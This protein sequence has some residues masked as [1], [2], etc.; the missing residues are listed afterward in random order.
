MIGNNNTNVKYD[1]LSIS[2]FRGSPTEIL[3]KIPRVIPIWNIVPRL[4]Y[5]SFG[6]I[7]KTIS[8]LLENLTKLRYNHLK[9]STSNALKKSSYVKWYCN[10]RGINSINEHL[11]NTS[12]NYKKVCY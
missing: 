7:S 4:L 6:E 9:D 10:I 1:Y 2:K 11:K 12:N 5:N 3:R 8:K